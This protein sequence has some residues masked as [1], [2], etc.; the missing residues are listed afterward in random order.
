VKTAK[1]GYILFFTVIL[2]LLTAAWACDGIFPTQT[3][4]NLPSDHNSSYGGYMHKGIRRG[5]SGSD[6]EEC[7]GH[8]L[9][10]QVYNYNGTLVV[11]QSCYQCHGNIWDEG[12]GGGGGGK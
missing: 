12:I 5:E 8:D 3:K 11:T 1:L 4:V 10:G 2:A 9:R 6:C 7:H